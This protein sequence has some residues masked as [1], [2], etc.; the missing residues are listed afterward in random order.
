VRIP[1]AAIYLAEG[2]PERAIL[3][4]APVAECSDESL[5]PT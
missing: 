4:L 3:L 1:A 5:I 2:S